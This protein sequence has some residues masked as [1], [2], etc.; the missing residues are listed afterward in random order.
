M[1]LSAYQRHVK[2]F[3]ASHRGMK[4]A[5]L[6]RAAARSWRGGGKSKGRRRRRKGSRRRSNMPGRAWSGRIYR[7]SAKGHKYRPSLRRRKGA[8]RWLPTSFYTRPCPR[9]RLGRGRCK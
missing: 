1:A 7:P 8:R 3:A 9:K 2:S 6:I 4:G 5:S